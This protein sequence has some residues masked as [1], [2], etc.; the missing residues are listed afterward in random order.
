M[1]RRKVIKPKRLRNGYFQKDEEPRLCQRIPDPGEAEVPEVLFI[2]GGE[3]GD[4]L[5]GEG[6]GGPPI[7]GPAAGEGFFPQPGPEGVMKG[8]T[9]R[10]Q[11]DELPMGMPQTLAFDRA[12]AGG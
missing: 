10:R 3:F 2:D 12:A 9:V 5:A 1:A 4:S 11:A 8:A 7:E 6:E